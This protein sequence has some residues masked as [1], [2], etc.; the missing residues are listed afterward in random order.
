MRLTLVTSVMLAAGFLGIDIGYY[1]HLGVGQW[2][3]I[4]NQRPIDEVIADEAT[5]PD[6][7]YQLLLA[8]QIQLQVPGFLLSILEHTV[9]MDM[10]SML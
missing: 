6:I 7:R 2:K 1:L 3:L 10:K 8:K 4:W 5:D 9:I